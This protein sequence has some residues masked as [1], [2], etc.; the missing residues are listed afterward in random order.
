MVYS[1]QNQVYPHK[2]TWYIRTK[3]GISKNDKED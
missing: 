2:K 3:N 1:E